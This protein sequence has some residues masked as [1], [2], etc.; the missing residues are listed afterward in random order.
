MLNALISAARPALGQ[1]RGENLAAAFGA[2]L[3][4]SCNPSGVFAQLD[5]LCKAGARVNEAVDDAG[6]SEYAPNDGARCCHKVVPAPHKDLQ[7]IRGG[8]FEAR[9]RALARGRPNQLTQRRL[10]TY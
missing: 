4:H 7:Q 5:L 2:R 8:P 6:H 10:H 1:H 9:K 3:A